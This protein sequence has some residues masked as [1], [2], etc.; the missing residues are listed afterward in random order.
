MYRKFNVKNFRCFEDF[1]IKNLKRINLFA[2]KNNVGKTALLEALF[3]HAGGYDPEL[4]I[5][6]VDPHDKSIFPLDFLFHNFDTSRKIELKSEDSENRVRE[7]LI[8]IPNRI[9]N[10]K[11]FQD[12][13]DQY[14]QSESRG[15]I[16][17][18]R[19]ISK[20]EGKEKISFLAFTP[21]GLQFIPFPP[22]QPSFPAVFLSS[23]LRLPYPETAER[24]SK[25]AQRRK[26]SLVV[27]ILQIIEPSLKSLLILSLGGL[28]M[29]YGDVG[30]SRI[31]LPLMGEGMVK[32]TDLVL[33]IATAQNGI[34]LIDE[35]ENGIHYSVLVDVWKA[36]IKSAEMFNCQVFAT[37]HSFECI[38]AAH[39]A[40]SEMYPEQND[41]D[42]SFYRLEKVDNKIVAKH[43]DREALEGAIDIGLEVR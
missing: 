36:V 34:V 26:E 23:K 1:E 14:I 25:L 41:Y 11:E 33:S 7:V 8:D 42:F 12:L 38:K 3:V 16:K 15:E 28:P 39:R 21:K 5:R 30:D 29:L 6:K 18:V 17:I 43:Y 22:P 4:L 40:F 19:L 9:E 35:I 24:F 31:P 2:G 13:V 20:E 10:T 32:L 37:T 27:E